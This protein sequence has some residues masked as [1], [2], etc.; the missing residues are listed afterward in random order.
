MLGSGYQVQLTKS[1]D[2]THNR[3]TLISPPDRAFGRRASRIEFS[4]DSF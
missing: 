1:G 4:G 3:V 2:F